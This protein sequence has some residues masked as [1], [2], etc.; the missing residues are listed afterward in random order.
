M[1]AI[2]GSSSIEIDAPLD[3]CW[4]AVAAVESGPEW[5]DGLESA[6]VKRRDEHGHATLVETTNDAKVRQV[7]STIEFAYD[8]PQRLTWRQ[9]EGDLKSVE[10]SWTL[11]DL[12]NGRTRATYNL[13]LDPGRIPEMALRG[14]LVDV[15]RRQLVGGRANE[16]A[17]RLDQTSS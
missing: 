15:L 11:E 13:A 5:Q 3:R 6:V 4:A 14:P 7:W 12:G 17:R 2:T 16:L 9:I 10:G 8:E 1:P